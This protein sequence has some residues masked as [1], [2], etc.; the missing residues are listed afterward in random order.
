MLHGGAARAGWLRRLR[1]AAAWTFLVLL[2][3][4]GGERRLADLEYTFHLLG[5]EARL[6]DEA[7][8]GDEVALRLVAV[9]DAS[10]PVVAVPASPLVPVHSTPRPADVSPRLIETPS[11]R[12][13][14][15]HSSALG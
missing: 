8:D 15:P 2:L 14:P 13:P 9:D 3:L 11:P 5:S 12:G 6:F 7:I 10:P 4:A 1:R